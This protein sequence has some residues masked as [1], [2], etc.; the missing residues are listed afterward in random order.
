MSARSPQSPHRSGAAARRL[1]RVAAAFAAIAAT[2]LALGLSP[3]LNS[4]TAAPHTHAAEAAAAHLDDAGTGLHR[5]QAGQ[6]RDTGDRLW[7]PGHLP[8]AA[9]TVPR[10]APVPDGAGPQAHLPHTTART[11]SD[12]QRAPPAN[13]S[14]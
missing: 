6:Q 14:T 8:P 3:A 9:P 12:S 10:A 11:T 13:S 4:A 5:T 7:P 2:L 1:P